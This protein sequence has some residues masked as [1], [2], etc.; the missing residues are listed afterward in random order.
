MRKKVVINRGDTDVRVA[1]LEDGKLVEFH[2][3]NINSKSIVGNIY[4]GVVRD[5]VPGLQAAFVDVGA[6]R[7]MFLHFMDV[8]PEALAMLGEN[9][10][11]ALREAA[12]TVI[13]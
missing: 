11:E 12:K 4:R 3:E 9:L 10:P 13:P 5:V 6:P 7:N 1:F 2:V 8:R